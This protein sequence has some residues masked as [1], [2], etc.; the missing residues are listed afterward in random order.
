MFDIN[1]NISITTLNRMIQRH[2][3]EDK[4]NQREFKNAQLHG[5]LH[6]KTRE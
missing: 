4:D 5:S 1:S 2:E 3:L 6:I